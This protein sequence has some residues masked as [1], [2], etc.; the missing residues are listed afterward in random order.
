METKC[1]SSNQKLEG[2]TPLQRLNN[3]RDHKQLATREEIKE[4]IK[5]IKVLFV[6]EGAKHL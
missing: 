2:Q 5:P 1:K 3:I 4:V 6:E